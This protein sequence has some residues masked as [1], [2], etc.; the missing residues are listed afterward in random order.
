MFNDNGNQDAVAHQ[1][2]MGPSILELRVPMPWSAIS[3][4]IIPLF[5]F[6]LLLS[7]FL[8]LLGL[9]IYSLQRLDLGSMSTYH[10]L[11]L[12]VWKSCGP[13][14]HHMETGRFW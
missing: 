14:S 10:C 8:L 6:P 4:V 13:S 11:L 2:L 1:I 12:F 3:T 7:F 9:L 5:I